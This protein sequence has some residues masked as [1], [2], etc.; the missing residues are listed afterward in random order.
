MK[1]RIDENHPW[2]IDDGDLST[3]RGTVTVNVRKEY[4]KA[5]LCLSYDAFELFKAME[6]KF[7]H[8]WT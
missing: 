2:V 3:W 1:E 5:W 8:F 4:I 7:N 6:Y